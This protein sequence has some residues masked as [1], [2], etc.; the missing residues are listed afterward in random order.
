MSD[1]DVSK[2]TLPN[3]AVEMTFVVNEFRRIH[4]PP[5]RK[6]E[7]EKFQDLNTPERQKLM[8]RLINRV[9]EI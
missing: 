8:E 9:K 7:P 1:L 5:Q 3:F 2:K 4:I 6:S